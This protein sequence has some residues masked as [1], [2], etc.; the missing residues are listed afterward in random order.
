M[1]RLTVNLP[2]HYELVLEQILKESR[3]GTT[4]EDIMIEALGLLTHLSGVKQM[5]PES[6]LLIVRPT[7]W[8]NL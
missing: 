8:P 2:D 4:V 6:S 3:Y 1:Y 5:H 7:A